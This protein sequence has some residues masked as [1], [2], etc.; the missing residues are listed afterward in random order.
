MDFSDQKPLPDDIA[1]AIR[2]LKVSLLSTLTRSGVPIT[3]PL[4]HI[5]DPQRPGIDYG[6]GLSYPAKADRARSNPHVGILF[7][8]QTHTGP[9]IAVAADATVLDSD[10]QAN[11]DRWVAFRLDREIAGLEQQDKPAE[12]WQDA[13]FYWVRLFVNCTPKA[14]YWWRDGRLDEPPD[15]WHAPADV[16]APLSDPTPNG[17]PTVATNAPAPPWEELAQ[18]L[19]RHEQPAPYLTLVTED[20]YP[21][22]FWTRGAEIVRSGFRI[23]VPNGAPWPLRG[24]GCLSFE[25]QGFGALVRGSFVGAVEQDGNDVIFHVDHA[26]PFHPI[27]KIMGELTSHLFPPADV[28][29]RQMARLHAELARRGATM[30]IVR[31]PPKEGHLMK[32]PEET[33]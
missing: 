7:H 11:T 24:K 19:L 12:R 8:D 23:D 9:L 4:A 29:T 5:W 13:V 14:V 1:W 30:P 20:G 26:I 15:R 31:R 17:S 16:A 27:M 33:Q 21:L 18:R 32:S 2:D 6:T 25:S 28:R 3:D 10:L 22:P